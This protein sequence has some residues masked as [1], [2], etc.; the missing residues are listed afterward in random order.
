MM[1]DISWKPV[2]IILA[3]HFPPKPFLRFQKHLHLNQIK[4]ATKSFFI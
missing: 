1:I 2:T 4:A 3:K